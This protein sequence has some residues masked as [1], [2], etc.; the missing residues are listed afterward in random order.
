VANIPRAIW[1]AGSRGDLIYVSNN[2]EAILGYTPQEM[3]TEQ[4]WLW[5]ERIHP[6]DAAR[7]QQAYQ[8]LF[9]TNQQL[10]IEYRARRKDGQWIWLHN[11]A[12]AARQRDGVLCADGLL[13][14]VTRRKEA[15]DALQQAKEAAEA[16]NRAKSQF[17]ANMS[18]NCA[19]QCHH[20]L[21]RDA[22]RPEVRR[23][24]RDSSNTPTTF[25]SAA[26]I[27]FSSSTIFWI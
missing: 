22:R 7:V 10:D 4:P 5:L 18:Q 12:P 3:T 26:N 11:R 21:L 9:T 20:Q 6:N 17:L 27:C 13:S 15:E 24:N 8:T 14:D 16:A 1:T 2:I 23:L 25:C 19:A